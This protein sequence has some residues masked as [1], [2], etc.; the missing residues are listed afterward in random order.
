MALRVL[1]DGRGRIEAQRLAVQQRA[2][3]GRGLVA[4]DPGRDVD[5]EREARGM[6]L[7]KAVFA[8]AQDLLEDRFGPLARIPTLEHPGDELVAEG[9]EAT[10]PLPRRHGAPKLVSLARR[11]ARGDHREL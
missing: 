3:E 2:G 1:D 8:E 6:G 10:A 5:Q 4:L 11:E 7:G 9:L